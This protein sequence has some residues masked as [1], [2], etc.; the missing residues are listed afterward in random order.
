[1]ASR[2]WVFTLNAD[3]SKGEHVKWIT[4]GEDCPVRS[5]L[6][7]GK[8]Q[9]LVCQV[10]RVAHVHVQGYIQFTHVMRLAGLKKISA[11][12]HWE[13]RRGT[14]AQA[15]DYAKKDES[16]VNG[17]WELGHE[18]DDQGKRNDLEK[19]GELV[20]AK[21]TNLEI[22]EECG[23]VAS[24][25]AKNIAFLRFVN[26]EAESDRQVQGVRVLCLYGPTGVGKTFAAVNF[27]AGGVDYYIAEAPSQRGSKLW[28]DGY[29][30]QHTLILDDF[31]G[32]YCTLA[33]LKRL[34]DVYKLK[35]EVK[36][37]F[38]WAVWT[39]VVITS[40]S[41][42]SAWYNKADMQVNLGPLKRRIQEIR[43]CENQGT[44]KRQDWDCHDLDED[45]V[46]YDVPAAAVQRSNVRVESPLLVDDE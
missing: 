11:A 20:K 15:R 3:E 16:R 8:I 43:L 38:A 9:Y 5:W 36:G 10:E 4:P 45:F 32:D 17:P 1:M 26:T 21:R 39:T 29:E 22:V 25:F 24:K 6:D 33:Y 46:A 42:P 7:C 23:A 31:D 2:N 41:H 14:H 19:I 18:K 12:A 40:N 37:G 13:F 44:Y 30:G 27:I 34:L 35:I 28:F